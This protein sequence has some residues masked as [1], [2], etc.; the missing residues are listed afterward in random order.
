MHFA[1]SSAA[2][3][4]IGGKTLE[5]RV[6]KSVKA[7][8]KKL[9][10]AIDSL[11][12]TGTIRLGKRREK[13]IPHIKELVPLPDLNDLVFGGWDLFKDNACV[14]VA[15]AG[16]WEKAHIDKM[17]GLMNGVEPMPAAF[18]Q[19]WVKNHHPI[20]AR[21]RS[22]FT[23]CNPIVGPGDWAMPVWRPATAAAM[24]SAAAVIS[25]H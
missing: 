4:T 7:V 6:I 10:L 22:D 11:S 5:G 21:S 20:R 3:F 12:Q 15:K 13:R 18:E 2:R 23:A 8:R 1:A 25:R 9:S 24:I 19:Q 17:A 14:A 16:V